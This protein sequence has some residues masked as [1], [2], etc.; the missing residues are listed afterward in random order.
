MHPIDAMVPHGCTGVQHREARQENG[1]AHDMPSRGTP[2]EAQPRNG[3]QQETGRKTKREHREQCLGHVVANGKW[4]WLTQEKQGEKQETHEMP[5][6]PP[7]KRMREKQPPARPSVKVE[8]STSGG[9]QQLAAK[10]AVASRTVTC[11][12]LG[13][14]AREET[15]R[16]P[17]TGTDR[18]AAGTG[19]KR[20]LRTKT[21]AA[22]A[23]EY[24][25]EEGSEEEDMKAPAMTQD[26]RMNKLFSY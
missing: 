10:D 20:R 6:P 18:R 12:D 4:A 11:G 5:V 3:R 25:S 14:H 19:P 22:V 13:L 7:S 15:Q 17:Q 16:L 26:K 23:L 2:G 8:E 21:P 1:C 9:D 24:S